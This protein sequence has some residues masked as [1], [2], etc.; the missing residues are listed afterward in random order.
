MYY[1]NKIETL[2]EIFGTSEIELTELYLNVSGKIFPIIDDVIITLK[3]HQIPSHITAETNLLNEEEE[4]DSSIGEDP[5]YP[6]DKEWRIAKDIQS[7]FGKE[8]KIYNEILPEHF[9]EFKRYFDIIDL[10]SLE[11]KR[12]CDLGCGIGRWSYFL[13]DTAKE[14]VLVDFSE[15]IFEAR[16]HLIESDNM[17][18]ILGDVLDL[19]FQDD[20]FDIIFSLGV[21]HHIPIPALQSVRDLAGLAPEFL[22]YIYYDLDNRGARFKSLFSSSI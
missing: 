12:I 20:T 18:F 22:F 7:T 4:I 8:W 17:V 6:L 16:K 15:S 21:L 19:P 5:H 1:D 11:S 13:K 14:I 10:K 9:E 3:P 2:S